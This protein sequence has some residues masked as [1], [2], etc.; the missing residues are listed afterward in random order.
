MN[1]RFQMNRMYQ[2]FQMNRM[3]QRFRMYQMY[4]KFRKNHHIY[5]LLL[6]YKKYLE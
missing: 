4:R 5:N 3:Y 2:R 6:K 1:Q